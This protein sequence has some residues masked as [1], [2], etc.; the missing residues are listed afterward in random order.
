MRRIAIILLS[1]A[2]LSVAVYAGDDKVPF[3]PGPAASY[4]THQTL[5]KITIAAIPYV[6]EEQAKEAFGKVNPMKYGVLPVLVI[7]ENNTG[8]TLRLELQAEYDDPGHR[9]IDAT[10]ASEVLYVGSSVKEPKLPGGSRPI[11]LPHRDKKGPL[12]TPEITTR[13]FA[14]KMLPDGDS[15][16]GFFYFQT[17]PVPGSKIVISGVK[18]AQSGK[19]YFFFEVPLDK[20]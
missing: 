10:P 13:A 16:F 12:N 11:P 5:D 14:A 7:F 6:T 1:I 20:P 17:E 15:A 9:H 4:P 2:A 19:D 18:D 3:K 8:K